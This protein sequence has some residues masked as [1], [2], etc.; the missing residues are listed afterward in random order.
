MADIDKKLLK[1]KGQIDAAKTGKAQEEG[2]MESVKARLND[3]VGCKTVSQAEKKLK[4]ID[5]EANKLSDELDDGIAEIEKDY[6]EL[7]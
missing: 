7:L 3:E 2:K 4:E 1:W 5:K 6:G